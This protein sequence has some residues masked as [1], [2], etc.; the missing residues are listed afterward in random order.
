MSDFNSILTLPTALRHDWGPG[1][2]VT[3]SLSSCPTLVSYLGHPARVSYLSKALFGQLARH[4]KLR[5][6]L[7]YSTHKC[8]IFTFSN[9]IHIARNRGRI[10]TCRTR[11]K[12]FLST[13]ALHIA[14]KIPTH[15][16]NVRYLFSCIFS[17]N[18]T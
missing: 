12:L 3:Q 11:F 5:L 18:F 2:D 15:F 7:L 13:F 8:K 1:H 4:P 16:P 9:L 10:E 6:F 14:Y 17:G